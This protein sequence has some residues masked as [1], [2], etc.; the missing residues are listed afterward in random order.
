MP[1]RHRFSLAYPAAHFC[2]P[3]CFHFNLYFAL[4]TSLRHPPMHP[5]PL[6]HCALPMAAALGNFLQA[7]YTIYSY[8]SLPIS[9]FP[10]SHSPSPSPSHSNRNLEPCKL[11]CGNGKHR[12]KQSDKGNMLANILHGVED[13]EHCCC[14][15][16]GQWWGLIKHSGAGR[17]WSGQRHWHCAEKRIWMTYLYCINV[18]LIWQHM[19]TCAGINVE[20]FIYARD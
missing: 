5:L 1:H 6:T 2:G 16:W 12:N 18:S 3:F 8:F 9:H 10:I 4:P 14:P 7:H 15:Q 11:L 13:C 20:Y 17:C 19:T